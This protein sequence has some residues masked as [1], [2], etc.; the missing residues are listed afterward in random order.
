MA[1]G[2]RREARPEV[3]VS[4]NSGI[5]TE[6]IAFLADLPPEFAVLGGDDVFISPLLALGAHGAILASAHIATAEFADL[7]TAWRAG[8][9]DQARVLGHRLA[10]LSAALFAEPNPSV[11][12][13]VLHAHG[14]IPTPAV[15]PPLLAAT[16]DATH[17]ALRCAEDVVGVAV[18]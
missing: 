11:V 15:R 1:V 5:D 13:A 3:D 4:G 8:N 17:A 7:V 16:P 9:V 10:P 6:T 18:K 12:K 2:A 14:R